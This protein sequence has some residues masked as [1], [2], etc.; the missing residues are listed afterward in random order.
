MAETI[1]IECT[2]CGTISRITFVTDTSDHDQ[3]QDPE[4][5]Y[6]CPACSSADT[7]QE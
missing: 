7:V 6:Y 2:D 3:K 4:Y 5:N 1:T